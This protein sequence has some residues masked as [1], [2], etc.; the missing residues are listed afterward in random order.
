MG[1][2]W[3]AHWTLWFRFHQTREQTQIGAEGDDILLL[4]LNIEL[5]GYQSHWSHWLRVQCC[6]TLL[7]TGPFPTFH[8]SL[9]PGFKLIQS[10]SGY[11]MWQLRSRWGRDLSHLCNADMKKSQWQPSL[12]WH[13]QCF[14]SNPGLNPAC[15]LSL[16]ICT[17]HAED[18]D[19]VVWMCIITLYLTAAFSSRDELLALYLFISVVT[20][21]HDSYL[22]S[23]SVSCS[24]HNGSL[25]CIFFPPAS[26]LSDECAWRCQPE[27]GDCSSLK[28]WDNRFILFNNNSR[29]LVLALMSASNWYRMLKKSAII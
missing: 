16:Y 17:A 28:G 26:S 7:L 10:N 19:M 22:I 5:T 6:I 13:L 3:W 15:G 8:N 21:R 12:S 4:L 24:C 27:R 1:I 25:G 18:N 23:S 14:M 11:V 29:D 2:G 9:G 20:W